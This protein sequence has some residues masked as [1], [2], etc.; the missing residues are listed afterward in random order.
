MLVAVLIGLCVGLWFTGVV[1]GLALI[2]AGEQAMG[3]AVLAGWL[4]GWVA[5]TVL[6]GLLRRGDGA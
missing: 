2:E 4:V 6:Y 1:V 3:A 5:G